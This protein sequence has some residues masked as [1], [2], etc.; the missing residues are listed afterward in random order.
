MARTVPDLCLLLSTM[1]SGD[2][3]DPLATTV[4][5]RSVRLAEDFAVPARVD[6]S[7][8]RVAITPDFGFAL[9]ERHMAEVFAEKTGLFRNTFHRAENTTPDCSGADESFEVLRA[10]G[11]LASQLEKVRTGPD[12]VGLNVRANVEEGLRYSAADVARAQALQTALH[13]RRQSFFQE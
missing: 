5:R 9:T 10:I 6:L 13:R 4:H 8:L 2:A 1:G 3:R 7:R 11:L 12:D